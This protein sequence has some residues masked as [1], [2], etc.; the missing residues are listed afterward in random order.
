VK[1]VAP[2]TPAAPGTAEGSREAEHAARL[3]A[4]ATVE[5]LLRLQSVTAALCR[6]RTPDE[7]A[8]VALG[9]GLAALGGACG[10]FL[11]ADGAS[12]L[13]ALRG[14]GVPQDPA[15][16]AQLRAGPALAAYR[17]GAPVFLDEG[18]DLPGRGRGEAVDARAGASVAALPLEV[19]GRVLGVL[20]VAF[21]AAR[22]L[23][24]VERDFAQALATQCAQALDSARLLVAER[25]ARAEAVAARRRLSFL[26]QL[27]ALL[28]EAPDRAAMLDGVLRLAVPVLGE[29]VG[30]YLPNEGGGLA[31]AAQHGPAALGTAVDAHLRRGAC[32]QVERS[33]SCGDVAVLP[34]V[35]GSGVTLPLIRVAPLCLRGRSLGT[36]AV[37]SPGGSR[38]EEGEDVAL[39]ADVCHRVAL[40][41]EHVRL[42]EEATAAA[43]A[44]EEFLH[45]A[46]HEL[47]APIATLRLAVHLLRREVRGGDPDACE[48]RLRVLDRQVTRLLGISETLLDV[49][50]ITAGRLELAPEDTDLTALAREVAVRFAD[51]AAEQGSSIEVDAPEAVR[52]SCDPGRLD[53]VLSNLVSNAVKYGRG[54][55]IRVSVRSAAG[56]AVVEVDD[57]GI[58]IPPEHQ[59]RIF[60]RFERAVSS[61]NYGGLGLG[62]WIARRLMDA[63]GG[64]IRVRSVAGAGSTFTVELPL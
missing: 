43:H 57:R 64:T 41:L 42:L 49:S 48:R 36:I 10:V 33:L 14:A 17:T 31:L 29:W 15:R 61:R 40:A 50:R 2:L 19:E 32:A 13:E 23:T 27:S 51:D 26:D 59:D 18:G 47:R 34:N 5:R 60:G 9:P 22:P 16:A 55:P 20:A 1:H 35:P 56:R 63:H 52:C 21:E 30:I 53:Q 11:V 6:A 62:L 12:E 54:A 46:S 58:G 39:V 24:Q 28:A 45:V 3:Q 4:E 38:A 44:R 37:A 8:A 7:V 25:L